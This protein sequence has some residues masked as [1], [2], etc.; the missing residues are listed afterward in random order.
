MQR[1]GRIRDRGQREVARSFTNT[2]DRL[3][4]GISALSA[5]AVDNVTVAGIVR[6]TS[7]SGSDAQTIFQVGNGASPRCELSLLATTGG[8]RY[9]TGTSAGQSATAPS[10]TLAPSDGWCLLAA[11][12]GAGTATPRFHKY[13]YISN[14]FVHENATVT[15]SS[16][17]STTQA[18]IG[19]NDGWNGLLSGSVGIIAVIG[20]VLNDDE[21]ERLPYALSSWMAL[22]PLSL[23]VLDQQATT[24]TVVDWT[25]KGGNQ[26]SVGGTAVDSTSIPA[27]GY[28]HPVILATR[29]ASGASSTTANAGSADIGCAGQAAGPAV[30]ATATD[31]AVDGS[32]LNAAAVTVPVVTAD[33]GSAVVTL[34][35]QPASTQVSPFGGLPAV[36]V[37]GLPAAIEIALSAGQATTSADAYNPTALTIPIV[38]AS[39]GPADVN[40]DGQNTQA[41]LA[42]NPGSADAASTA[43]DP[44]VATS[45]SGT[46]TADTAGVAVTAET[47]GVAAG[48]NSGSATADTAAFNAV[49]ATL[50][51]GTA[52]AGMADVVA[53]AYNGTAQPDLIVSA[54]SGDIAATA[55]DPIASTEASATANAGAADVAATAGGPQG[56]LTLTITA[57]D[58][59]A[60]AD[61][62]GATAST[63]A[64]ATA[65]ALEAQAD[66]QAFGAL[67]QVLASAGVAEVGIDAGSIPKQRRPGI[68]TAGTHRYRLTAGAHRGPN[69]SSGG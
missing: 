40:S 34:D 24:Q 2:N 62:F 66:A 27:F 31:S 46:A 33:A 28:G 18:V 38:T 35:G 39:A 57:A 5:T 16:P 23:W 30:V 67:V 61:A 8:F 7:V 15:V 44:A 4:V 12:K 42:A 45:S 6:L 65:E 41:D 50:A 47:A 13:S 19:N 21:F 20:R 26:A 3:Y 48:T 69:F 17:A 68:L 52:A 55:N 60:V 58:A 43:N 53:D 59:S 36:A 51:E 22:A 49:A 1:R 63:A 25:G 9:R 11:S 14:S 64:A 54:G 37:D 29:E 32:A 56:V 10:I